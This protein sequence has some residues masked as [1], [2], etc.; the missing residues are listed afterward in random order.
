M[1]QAGNSGTWLTED[2]V[3]VLES[4]EGVEVLVLCSADRDLDLGPSEDGVAL[5]VHRV[6]DPK[7]FGPGLSMPWDVSAQPPP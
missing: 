7:A 6:T 2:L 1:G 5:V 3:P 4:M